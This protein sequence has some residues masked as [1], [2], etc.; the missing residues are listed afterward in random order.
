MQ[1]HKAL[2]II[3]TVAAATTL[4]L[5]AATTLALSAKLTIG[6]NPTDP[7]SRTLVLAGPLAQPE[8]CPKPTLHWGAFPVKAEDLQASCPALTLRADVATILTAGADGT[9]PPGRRAT[10]DDM[11]LWRPADWAE[12]ANRCFA[13]KTYPPIDANSQGILFYDYELLDPSTEDGWRAHQQVL[14]NAKRLYPNRTLVA[15]GWP[16]QY[17][18]AIDTPAGQTDIRAKHDALGHFWALQDAISCGSY[19]PPPNSVAGGSLAMGRRLRLN[20]LE[21]HRIANS[22]TKKK[23]VLNF[24]MYRYAGSWSTAAMSESDLRICWEASHGLGGTPVLFEWTEQGPQD[25]SA[26]FKAEF[27]KAA[28]AWGAATR[29]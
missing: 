22:T 4:A 23:P 12:F 6:A 29:P 8:P 3:L 13:L 24:L 5:A 28:R 11:P 9:T 7:A 14:R 20:T 18:D 2:A 17:H 15:Y 19:I 21:A 16:R 1:C 26:A 27:P 25:W 10:D